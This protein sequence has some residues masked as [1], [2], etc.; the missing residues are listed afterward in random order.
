MRIITVYVQ[1][2]KG[3]FSADNCRG[4][5]LLACFKEHYYM[6]WYLCSYRFSGRRPTSWLTRLALCLTPGWGMGLIHPQPVSCHLQGGGGGGTML[7]QFLSTCWKCNLSRKLSIYFFC[8][9]LHCFQIFSHRCTVAQQRILETSQDAQQLIKSLGEE[10]N[11]C[12]LK[13]R[14]DQYCL[15]HFK[16]YTLC[17]RTLRQYFR[18]NRIAQNL[19]KIYHGFTIE[20]ALWGK[21]RYTVHCSIQCLKGTVAWD[22]FLA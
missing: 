1:T 18:D 15:T 12:D 17:V 11:L 13:R 2:G 9:F 19:H 20:K 10:C 14:S 7:H 5:H 22:G 16:K 4:I 6:R 21:W 3:R 8:I